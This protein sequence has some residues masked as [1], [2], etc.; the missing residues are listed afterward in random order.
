MSLSYVI[1]D[2]HDRYDLLK[3]RCRRLPACDASGDADNAW[4]YV[5]RGP[6]SRQSIGFVVALGTLGGSSFV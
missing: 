2:L 4:D 1:A 3:N 5:D 6:Q